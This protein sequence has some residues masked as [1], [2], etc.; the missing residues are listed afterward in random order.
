M[1]KIADS[2]HRVKEKTGGL[3]DRYLGKGRFDLMSPIA[4]IELSK[5]CEACVCGPKAKYPPR[6]WERGLRISQYIDSA[7]RHLQKL[8]AGLND[9]DHA[10]AAFWNCMCLVHTLLKIES[11]ELPSYLLDDLPWKQLKSQK[12]T[13][14]RL[15]SR[16]H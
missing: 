3:R 16:S 7:I 4:L 13:T 15:K 2:G 12:Q 11:G 5:Y 6:N 8:L 14:R 9:E 10:I 1:K